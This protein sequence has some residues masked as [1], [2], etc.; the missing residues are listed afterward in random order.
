MSSE[1]KENFK[2]EFE[3]ALKRKVKK[4]ALYNKK[5]ESIIYRFRFFI[6]DKN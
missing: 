1:E 2:K 4:Q 6:F 3:K 5:T